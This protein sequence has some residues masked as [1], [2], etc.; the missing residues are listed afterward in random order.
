MMMNTFIFICQLYDLFNKSVF[1][2][3]IKNYHDCEGLF[4]EYK[5][6]LRHETLLR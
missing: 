4:Q 1:M 5:N 2:A 3:F 6:G